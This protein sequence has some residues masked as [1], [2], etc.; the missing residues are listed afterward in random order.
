MINRDSCRLSPAQ[1]AALEYIE[2]YARNL[3]TVG[4]AELPNVLAM[5]NITVEKFEQALLQIKEH[6]RVGLNFHPDRIAHSGKSVAQ[7][8]LEDGFYR[9]QFETHLSNG[10]LDPTG[11]GLRAG[12]E[13]AVF[14]KVFSANQADLGERPKYGGLDLML[15]PDG[16]C[17]RYGSCYFLLASTATKRSSF[18]Y[19]DSHRNPVEKGTLNVFEPIIA[20]L[21]T[22]CFERSFALGRHATSPAWLVDHLIRNLKGPDTDPGRLPPSRNLNHYIEAQVHGPVSLAADVDIL[23]ADPCYKDTKFEQIFESICQ[24]YKL[25]FHWHAGFKLAVDAVPDDFRGPKMPA[26]ARRISTAD[27]FDAYMIGQAAVDLKAHPQNWSDRGSYDTVLQELKCLW[28]VL[29]QFG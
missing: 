26:L 11:A 10:R 13:D 8:L 14:G 17:P 23:V 27:Y 15:Q 22:E 29:V 18:T 28:H 4:Q 24:T 12:W 1:H 16:P 9:N 20:A 2:E 5:S 19:M 7:S 21:M 6:A 25:N 3:R